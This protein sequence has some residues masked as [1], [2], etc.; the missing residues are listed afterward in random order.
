[1]YHCIRV[2][3]EVQE[4]EVGEA[5]QGS[6]ADDAPVG[7]QGRHLFIFKPYFGSNVYMRLVCALVVCFIYMLFSCLVPNLC[8]TLP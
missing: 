6:I 2:E 8:I 5:Q 7:S 1:M 3:T 4:Q